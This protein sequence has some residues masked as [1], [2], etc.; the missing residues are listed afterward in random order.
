MKAPRLRIHD[1][2]MRLATQMQ[3]LV[4]Q[5]GTDEAQKHMFRKESLLAI[6]GVQEYLDILSEETGIPVLSRPL[7]PLAQALL[8]M[9]TTRSTPKMFDEKAKSRPPATIAELN[10]KYLCAWL[11]RLYRNNGLGRKDSSKRLRRVLAGIFP[12]DMKLPSERSLEDWF[13]K[14]A[15][16][17]EWFDAYSKIFSSEHTDSKKIHGLTNGEIDGIA[18][19]TIAQNIRNF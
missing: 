10:R 14:T 1:A 9:E 13:D 17:G 16:T 18:K 19:I 12:V 7:L 8:D 15:R 5:L 11:Q 4:E 3:W 2:A 6:I